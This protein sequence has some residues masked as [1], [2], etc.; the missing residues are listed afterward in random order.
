MVQTW[1]KVKSIYQLLNG[2]TVKDDSPILTIYSVQ[3]PL[4]K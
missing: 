2:R 4:K 1:L 3:N